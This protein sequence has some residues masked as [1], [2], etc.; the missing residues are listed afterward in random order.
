M[1]R[2]RHR[3][4]RVGQPAGP[5]ILLQRACSSFCSY[6]K[7]SGTVSGDL[8]E[9]IGPV[10]G[11][12]EYVDHVVW[13][14]GLTLAYPDFF[15]PTGGSRESD[16]RSQECT[17]HFTLKCR[18]AE[19]GPSSRPSGVEHLRQRHRRA[20][21]HSL[22]STSVIGAVASRA[23]GP[24]GMATPAWS[25]AFDRPRRTS[26][27]SKSHCPSSTKMTRVPLV[28]RSATRSASQ[29]VSRTQPWDSALDTFP[30]YGVPWI[31]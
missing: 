5:G 13:R 7:I 23:D 19:P 12:G 22:E 18:I 25:A 10:T 9:A 14:V 3:C 2:E 28:T 1:F 31:P 11:P 20:S 6:G 24:V 16:P 29:F 26:C 15:R 27:Q 4:V 21:A 30:G 17:D 8:P